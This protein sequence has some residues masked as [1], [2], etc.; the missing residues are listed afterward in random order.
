MAEEDIS[1]KPFLLGDP[2][3][4]ALAACVSGATA[5]L[6]TGL[7]D[8]RRIDW[9]GLAGDIAQKIEKMFDIRLIDVFTAA[10]KD[11]AALTDCADRAKHPADETISLPMVEHSIETTLRPCLDVVIEPRPA[12]R[13]TFEIACELD[14]KGLVLKIQDACIRAL[15]IGSCGAKATVKCEGIVLIERDTRALEIPGEIVLRQGVPINPRN[16]MGFVSGTIR[17]PS[18]STFAMS[19]RPAVI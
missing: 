13:I 5:A 1:L 2:P 4:E 19:T 11:Y 6:K 12:I 14:I 7:V 18:T 3:H 8:P 10:W 16:S 15:R 17:G 9:S